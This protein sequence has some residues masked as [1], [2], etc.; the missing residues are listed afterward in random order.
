LSRKQAINSSTPLET[1][2]P[3]VAEAT[4]THTSCNTRSPK[5][6]SPSIESLRENDSEFEAHGIEEIRRIVLEDL[7]ETGTEHSL[8]SPKEEKQ[9]SVASQSFDGS[10]RYS[11][12]ISVHWDMRTF[13]K[14]QFGELGTTAL[15]S[16]ITLTG[17][18]LHA[19]ATTVKEYVKL[20][21]PATGLAL[22]ELLQKTSESGRLESEGKSRSGNI[23][24]V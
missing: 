15:G 2:P 19:Q 5:S 14:T 8:G 1:T 9:S 17:T 12:A 3:H 22:L 4:L 18:A 24:R 21:W 20:N 7:L 11:T 10:T 16:V 13:I 23:E 6:P